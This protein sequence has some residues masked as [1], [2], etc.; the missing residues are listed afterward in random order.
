MQF[1]YALHV[2]FAVITWVLLAATAVSGILRY[3]GK[4]PVPLLLHRI[5]AG[6]TLAFAL[7]HG[8]AHLYWN[9]F[10]IR[11]PLLTGMLPLALVL[12]NLL[13]GITGLKSRVKMRLHALLGIIALGVA[14]FHAG[15]MIAQRLSVTALAFLS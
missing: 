14:T 6:F 11:L 9:S 1:F 3:Y 13:L 4:K 10:Q 8:F 7:W 2:P 15:W 5:L 12:A